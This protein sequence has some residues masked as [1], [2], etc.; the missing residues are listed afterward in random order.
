MDNYRWK[1]RRNNIG[2]GMTEPTS[3]QHLDQDDKAF[4]VAF[5]NSLK[6]DM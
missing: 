6:L 3:R 5:K 2:A 1:E 4:I